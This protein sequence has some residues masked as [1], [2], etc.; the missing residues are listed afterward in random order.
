MTGPIPS[1]AELLHQAADEI[2]RAYVDRTDA[3]TAAISLVSMLRERARRLETPTVTPDEP[4]AEAPT[5][6]QDEP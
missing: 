5:V 6:T 2:E 1:I 4:E 3:P